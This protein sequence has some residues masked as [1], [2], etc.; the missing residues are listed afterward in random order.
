MKLWVTF[1]HLQ[2][3]KVEISP[4]IDVDAVKDTILSRMGVTG[5]PSARVLLRRADGSPLDPMRSLARQAVYEGEHCELELLPPIE[6]VDE[7]PLAIVHEE[8][9]GAPPWQEELMITRDADGLGLSRSRHGAVEKLTEAVL[10][11]WGVSLQVPQSWPQCL[12]DV[13]V[14]EVRIAVISRATGQMIGEKVFNR[15]AQ[16]GS[17]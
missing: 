11:D 8:G 1:A 10:E 7:E 14:R 16:L 9:Q 3:T 13:S 2:P 15:N 12:E 5:M 17:S 4:D 6:L